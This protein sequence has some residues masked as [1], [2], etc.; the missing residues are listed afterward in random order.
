MRICNHMHPGVLCRVSSCHVVPSS[1]RMLVAY[2]RSAPRGIVLAR[3]IRIGADSG[4]DVI[5]GLRVLA[6]VA[7]RRD[8]GGTWTRCRLSD[9][10]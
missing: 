8:S 10:H 6:P 4:S 9:E 3:I 7:A 5:K 2:I 1:S